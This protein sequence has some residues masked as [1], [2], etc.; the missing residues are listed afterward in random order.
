GGGV[1]PGGRGGRVV[2]GGGGDLELVLDIAG[3]G[4]G[5]GGGG[6]R[7]RRGRG[8]GGRL[9]HRR[10]G[11]KPRL[12][13]RPRR[14]CSQRRCRRWSHRIVGAVI[15]PC[16]ERALLPIRTDRLRGKELVER[17]WGGDPRLVRASSE[18]SRRGL[19]RI[20]PEQ[21]RHLPR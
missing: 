16:Y 20:G 3:G 1:R 11:G 14:R 10:R 8:R 2:L 21:Q 13:G 17:H 5:G 6:W 15:L 12:R 19:L 7:G 18:E 9:W 4:G